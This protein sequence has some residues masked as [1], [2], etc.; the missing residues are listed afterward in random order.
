L[1][2]FYQVLGDTFVEKVRFCR[3]WTGGAVSVQVY[4]S[5]R[6]THPVAW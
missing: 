2:T 6:C 4:R 5:G 1:I 3:S